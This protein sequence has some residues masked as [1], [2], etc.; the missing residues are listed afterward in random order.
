M[1]FKGFRRLVVLAVVVA[2]AI[3]VPAVGNGAARR[4]SA[5]ACPCVTVTSFTPASGPIGTTVTITGSGFTGSGSTC[6]GL[7]VRFNG[8][9]GGCTFVSATTIKTT[10]PALASTGPLSVNDQVASSPNFAV[11]TGVT[12]TPA[13]NRVG[14]PVSVNGSAFGA[15][16]AVDLYFDLTDEA[17]VTTDANGNFVAS[18]I[19]LVPSSAVPGVH[20][21]TAVGRHSGLAAQ[22]SFRVAMSWNEVGF[23]GAGTNT[24]PFENVLSPSTV[25]GLNLDWSFPT[26]AFVDRSV[27]AVAGPV[28]AHGTVYVAE[29]QGSGGNDLYA[30]DAST[31]ARL[32][33]GSVPSDALLGS[34]AVGNSRVYVVDS[35]YSTLRIWPTTCTSPC[36]QS[37]SSVGKSPIG[38]PKIDGSTVFTSDFTTAPDAWPAA[39]AANCSPTWVGQTQ[40][41]P[42]PA[43]S[44][45]RVFVSGTYGAYDGIQAYAEA[46]CGASTCAPLWYGTYGGLETGAAPVVAN[47]VVYELTEFALRAFQARGC[48]TSPCQPLWADSIAGPGQV[49]VNGGVVYV[50]GLDET[51]AGRP[52]T[53]FALDAAT[54][55]TIWK[56]SLPSASDQSAAVVAN[57]VVYVD[58]TGGSPSRLLAY[59]TSCSTPCSPLWQAVASTSGYSSAPVVVNGM[60]YVASGDKSVDAF[61]LNPPAAPAAP[62]PSSLRPN[63]LLPVRG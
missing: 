46:G 9:I 33:Y 30:L 26:N 35:K 32:W 43:V 44:G 49:A 58:A 28:G 56:A 17:V 59:P 3:S 14:T 38:D 40:G 7:T 31:G 4:P 60:L 20:W 22:K 45:G 53:L 57:G 8:T 5:T 16:E 48:A 11:T 54:G 10:V 34:P 18:S 19:F 55:S 1:G 15:Y 24:N 27:P 25:G 21:I 42:T 51:V 36:P 50:A 12:V 61:D 29:Q 52:P 23:N 47:G 13:S 62:D 37:G 6:T 2:T 41:D 39:C 63:L